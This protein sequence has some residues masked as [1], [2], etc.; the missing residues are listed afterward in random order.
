M[1]NTSLYE[2]EQLD[3]READEQNKKSYQLP[4]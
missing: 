3:W 1:T 2:A 4:K